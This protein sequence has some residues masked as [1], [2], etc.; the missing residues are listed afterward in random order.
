MKQCL[1]I[2]FK[3]S[4]G[5]NFVKDTV[6]KHAYK[7]EIEGTAFVSG[8]QIQIV[9][10]GVKENMDEFIGILHKGSRIARPDEVEIE[11]FAKERE[12]RGVFRVIE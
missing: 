5:S 1:R 2:T 12:Y 6:K 8:D 3:L 9:A 11:S 7:L 4:P 10:C